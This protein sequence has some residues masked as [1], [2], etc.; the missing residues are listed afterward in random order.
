[1][2]TI[3]INSLLGDPARVLRKVSHDLRETTRDLRESNPSTQTYVI[4]GL[5]GVA[6]LATAYVLL[7]DSGPPQPASGTLGQLP[8]GEGVVDPGYT[9]DVCGLGPSYP[10]F[11]WD[12]VDCVPSITTPPGIYIVDDCQDFLFVTG[13]DGPQPD[14]LEAR[15][16]NA[17]AQSQEGGGGGI[18][19]LKSN[20]SDANPTDIVTSFLSAWWPQCQW[21]PSPDGA[22]RI[23]QMYMALSIMVGRL[24]SDQG[25]N[26]I[27]ANSPSMVDEAV[28][29]LLIELGFT[30]FTPELV[31]EIPLP[32]YAGDLPPAYELPTSGPAV[33]CCFYELATAYIDPDTKLRVTGGGVIQCPGGGEQWEMHGRV[34]PGSLIDYYTNDDR[35][36]I[37]VISTPDGNP[38]VLPVCG[39]DA[40][41]PGTPPPLPPAHPQPPEIPPPHGGPGDLVAPPQLEL[42]DP[43]E[44]K[45]LEVPKNVEH[46][47]RISDMPNGIYKIR[48]V[49]S[50][51]YRAPAHKFVG[52]EDAGGPWGGGDPEAGFVWDTKDQLTYSQKEFIDYNVK[53]TF[54]G[55]EMTRY[56]S[57]TDSPTGTP[58]INALFGCQ[59]D[60]ACGWNG[61]YVSYFKPRLVWSGNGLLLQFRSRRVIQG[62]TALNPEAIHFEAVIFWHK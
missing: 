37:A 50:A 1:M 25:G 40:P 53:K 29:D 57:N 23:V 58:M 24:I 14:D 22:P 62:I 46:S 28:G 60:D 19:G 2:R 4:G 11:A 33:D 59:S 13:D 36:R 8:G 9:P 30:E 3:G 32:M 38:I 15:I 56:A 42:P 45:L 49:F 52:G 12:G 61:K 20:P 16:A 17:A 54:A 31:S 34:I 39:P 44:Y 21:P 10:G 47:T 51:K 27:G 7:A 35:Q 41:I 55:V 5:V 43:V 26:V 18:L 6:G 48:L